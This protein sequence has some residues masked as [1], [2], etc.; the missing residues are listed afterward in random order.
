M[1]RKMHRETNALA[2]AYRAGKLSRREFVSRLLGL[3]LSAPTIAGIVAEISPAA[4]EAMDLKGNVRFLVGPWS[5]NEV[6]IQKKIGEG[7]S[8]IHPDVTFEFRLYDWETDDQEINTS[9]AS[10]AHDI[11]MTTESAYPDYEVSDVFVDLTSLVNDSSFAE[12]KA[13][14]LYLDRTLGFGPRIMGLPISFHVESALFVNMDMVNAASYD[15]TFADSWDTFRDC[16]AKM[17][18]PGEVYGIALGLQPYGEWYQVLRAAGGSFLTPE[19]NAPNVNKPEV[20]NA[21]ERM[22]S[23]FKDNI[24]APLGTYNYDNAPAAFA[25]GKVA[26]LSIDLA[27]TTVVELPL[28]FNWKLIPNPPQA[29][30]RMN[31]NDI[32]Y[33]MINSQSDNQELMWEVVKWWTTGENDAYWADNSGTYPARVDAL[34]K[35]YGTNAAPQLAEALPAYKKYSVGLE[36]FPGWAGVESL[37]SAEVQK[38]FSGDETAEDAVANVEKIVQQETGL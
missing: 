27:A 11:Y 4:A 24:A 5:P 28:P 2:D 22:A 36:N 34:E 26:I 21:T 30:G 6:E 16:L 29:A 20:V 18:K 14:Y 17:N 1:K 32:T 35:G 19:L 13:K 23:L 25:A 9:A 10:G 3:G 38:C 37:A 33:Y 8:A 31:F 12:E 15:E 7:F